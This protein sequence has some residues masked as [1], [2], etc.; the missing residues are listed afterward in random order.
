MSNGSQIYCRSKRSDPLF[1]RSNTL[2]SKDPPG[3]AAQPWCC[4]RRKRKKLFA[5]SHRFV[6]TLSLIQIDKDT[7]LRYSLSTHADLISIK[8]LTLGKVTGEAL[9]GN[10]RNI[11]HQMCFWNDEACYGA[12]CA[13]G[14]FLL[15]CT[16]Q[17]NVVMDNENRQAYKLW[18]RKKVFSIHV[19]AWKG[20]MQVIIICTI[21]TI[22]MLKQIHS[23]KPHPK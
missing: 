23:E 2:I 14:C 22:P 19:W 8:S 11:F 16:E 18:R 7:D 9:R 3:G 4:G 15:F 1:I 17:S 12:G 20:S 6:F 13:Q 21:P 5:A 10:E